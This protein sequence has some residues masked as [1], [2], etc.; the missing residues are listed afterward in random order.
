[1]PGAECVSNYSA[2]H[3]PKT[4]YRDFRWSDPHITNNNYVYQLMISERNNYTIT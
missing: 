4:V 1:M 3:T 2:K